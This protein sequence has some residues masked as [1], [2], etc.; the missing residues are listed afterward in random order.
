ME[1]RELL[2]GFKREIE[3]LY[4]NKLKG[5]VLFGSWARGDATE[6][7][8]ID[9]LIILK[10]KIVPGMEIDR[11]VDIITEMNLKYRELISIYPISEKDYYTINS[12]LLINVRKEGVLV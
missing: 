1:I 7:S 8:D 11:M 12:P 2:K 4:P 5:I 3:R 6:D 9:L 10:G